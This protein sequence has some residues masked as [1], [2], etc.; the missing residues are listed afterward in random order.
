MK[1]V[2]CIF[3]FLTCSSNAVMAESYQPHPLELA[4]EEGVNCSW[5]TM[6]MKQYDTCMKRKKFF[7]K[8]TPEEKVKYNEAVRER[9]LQQLKD[10]VRRLESDSY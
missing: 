2:L 6:R 9:E 4:P 5:S 8:M 7:E 10:R 3:V 1:I